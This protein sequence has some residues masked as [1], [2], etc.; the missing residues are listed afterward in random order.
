MISKNN[1]KSISNHIF[2]ITIV[3]GLRALLRT[4]FFQNNVKMYSKF[5]YY[6]NKEMFGMVVR[7]KLLVDTL[8]SRV[9]Q[10]RYA[11]VLLHNSTKKKKKTW[12]NFS[13]TIQELSRIF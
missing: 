13:K 8:K 6:F 12:D 2:G 9:A 5:S 10:S 1:R 11:S 3:D 4:H 7:K